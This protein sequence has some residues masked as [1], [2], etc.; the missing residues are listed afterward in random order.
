MSEVKHKVISLDYK[1]YRDT[2]EGEMI[3]TTEG[4]EPLTFMSGVSQMIPEFEAQVINLNVGD[5]FSFGIKSE[6]AYGTRTED[7]IIELPQDMFKQD[8]KL[9][10]EIAVDNIVPLQDQQGQV[11]P[12]KVVSINE[13][14]VTM[15][16]NHPLADQDLHFIG[17]V[18]EVREAT[19]EEVEQSQGHVH[20]EACNH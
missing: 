16:V 20:T 2:A 18:V 17:S 10:D 12:A 6:N 1:L 5:T 9:I 13:E 19:T 15:D 8:G 3:E 14:S 4:K 11:V 7:A